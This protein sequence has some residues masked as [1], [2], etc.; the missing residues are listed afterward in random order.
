MPS[1]LYRAGVKEW[2]M[3]AKIALKAEDMSVHLRRMQ[4]AQRLHDELFHP[5]IVR[6]EAGR[7]IAHLALHLAKYCG[8]IKAASLEGDESRYRR[9]IVDSAIIASSAATALHIDLSVSEFAFS[10]ED[11]F[12]FEDVMVISVGK[13]AKAVEALDHVEDFPSR[14]VWSEE[15]PKI[16]ACAARQIE[17]WGADVIQSI[18][19]RLDFVRKKNPFYLELMSEAKHGILE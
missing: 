11:D 12:E 9:A 7:R 19:A 17:G 15:F 10:C 13:L 5:E 4:S 8:D 2:S 14:R 16:F 3:S 18:F 1:R 6:L